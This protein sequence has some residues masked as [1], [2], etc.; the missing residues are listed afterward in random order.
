LRAI[1]SNISARTRAVR[2]AS[3]ARSITGPNL[4]QIA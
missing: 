2:T 3:R 1:T 4:P